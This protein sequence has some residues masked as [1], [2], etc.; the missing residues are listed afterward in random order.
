MMMVEE[1]NIW[2]AAE[3]M[4]KLYGADAAIHSADQRPN[5]RRANRAVGSLN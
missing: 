2:R 3:Q 4:R 1:I 5:G